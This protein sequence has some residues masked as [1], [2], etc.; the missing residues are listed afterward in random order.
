MTEIPDETQVRDDESKD[1]DE[2]LI[3]LTS[4]TEV[5]AAS[6]HG[7]S[8]LQNDLQTMQERRE[9]GWSWLQIASSE[10]GLDPLATLTGITANLGI[11]IGSFRRALARS[12]QKEG[13]RITSI[14]GLL[15]VS[16]QRVSTLVSA[17]RSD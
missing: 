13:M 2:A 10:D 7:L 15:E 14:A 1:K 3:A 5:A 12:L 6:A 11:A 8:A 9:H 17:R 16:R 4:L